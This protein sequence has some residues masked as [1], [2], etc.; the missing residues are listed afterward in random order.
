MGEV[1]LAMVTLVDSIVG[2]EDPSTRKQ[3][4]IVLTELWNKL[5]Q[6]GCATSYPLRRP[7]TI[8]PENPTP[9]NIKEFAAEESAPWPKTDKDALP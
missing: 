4:V 3:I 5:Q 9:E 1:D 8:G 2:I 7:P 6:A